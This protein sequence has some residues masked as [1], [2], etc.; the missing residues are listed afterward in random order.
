MLDLI[1]CGDD[2]RFTSF[3]LRAQHR[4]ALEE[5]MAEWVA[6]RELD[7]VLAEF[8]RADAAIAPVLNM[9]GILEDP[10]FA[11][12]DSIIEYNTLDGRGSI[13]RRRVLTALVHGLDRLCSTGVLLP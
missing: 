12:R 13:G 1:G 10:H 5:L 7:D 3:Q 8:E 2:E 6:Q 9:D 11:S 4:D